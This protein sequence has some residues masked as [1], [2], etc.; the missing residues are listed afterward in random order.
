M[1]LFWICLDV[2]TPSLKCENAG[3]S[4]FTY[5]LSVPH[6]ILDDLTMCL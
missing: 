1:V 5:L 6:L 3:S 4:V 2:N